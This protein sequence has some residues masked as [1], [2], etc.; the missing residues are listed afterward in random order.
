[1]LVRADHKHRHTNTPLR[2]RAYLDDPSESSNSFLNTSKP[3]PLNCKWYLVSCARA[4]LLLIF[5]GDYSS[6]KQTRLISE[7]ATPFIRLRV[8]DDR[9]TPKEPIGF[10]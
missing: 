10:R 6:L 9:K 1:M 2:V 3:L 4:D 7:L 8:S 5:I